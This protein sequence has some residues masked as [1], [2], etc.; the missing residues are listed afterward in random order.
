MAHH[1]AAYSTIS[2]IMACCRGVTALSAI[3]KPRGALAFIATCAT[4][5]CRS[6][7]GT[8]EAMARAGRH[9]AAWRHT[10]RWRWEWIPVPYPMWRANLR[11]SSGV[12]VFSPDHVCLVV[13]ASGWVLVLLKTNVFFCRY[14]FGPTHFYMDPDRPNTNKRTGSR[15]E[16]KPSGLAQS[17]PFTSKPVKPTFCTKPYLTT[18]FFHAYQAKLG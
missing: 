17:G 1:T 15:Q 9:L 7:G 4:R 8:N 12:Q 6:A 5:S 3:M 11:S 14:V 18:L 16:T 2:P 10:W 13:A